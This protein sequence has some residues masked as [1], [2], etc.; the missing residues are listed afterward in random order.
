MLE[1]PVE[2]SS[3]EMPW[4]SWQLTLSRKS[5]GVLRKKSKMAEATSQHSDRLSNCFSP[6]YFYLCLQHHG[7]CLQ[8]SAAGLEVDVRRL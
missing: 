1:T 8:V 5:N 7:P 2:G 3:S 6:A 4:L